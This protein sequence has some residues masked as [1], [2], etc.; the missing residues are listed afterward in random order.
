MDIL[1]KEVGNFLCKFF[2]FGYLNFYIVWVIYYG[3]DFK[4]DI[5]GI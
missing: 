3:L 1:I 5:K 4:K 2:Y